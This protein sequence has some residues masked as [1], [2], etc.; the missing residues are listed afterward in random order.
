MVYKSIRICY[1]TILNSHG[2]VS[3]NKEVYRLVHAI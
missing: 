2:F 1:N 3:Q